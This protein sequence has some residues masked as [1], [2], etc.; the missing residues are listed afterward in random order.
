MSF[1]TNNKQQTTP[2]CA[3]YAPTP[4]PPRRADSHYAPTPTT[5]PLPRGLVLAS[6]VCLAWSSA[7]RRRRLPSR[8]HLPRHP[9]LALV[10]LQA[11]AFGMLLS[12]QGRAGRYGR[13]PLVRA[14]AIRAMNLFEP[15]PLPPR[16]VDLARLVLVELLGHDKWYDA[17][18]GSLL[19][20]LV[21]LGA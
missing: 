5:R 3:H 20:F 14:E 9:S 15:L 1:I 13:R 18:S 6:P 16:A 2:L 11:V 19:S 10:V 4:Q 21:I 12:P 8:L 17:F 7:I